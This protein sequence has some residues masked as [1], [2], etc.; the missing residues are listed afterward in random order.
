VAPALDRLNQDTR[1]NFYDCIR[2]LAVTLVLFG[3]YRGLLLPGGSI[4]VSIFFCLSGLLICRILIGLPARSP[5]NIAR[6]IFRRL[7][8]VWP[9]MA[10]QVFLVLGLMAWRQH[11][12]VGQYLAEMPGLLTFT[13]ASFVEWQWLGF[14]PAVLWTLRAEFWFYVLFAAAFYVAGRERIAALAV[15]GIAISW[16]CKYSLGH[17]S[18]MYTMVYLDQLMYGALAALAIDAAPGWLRYFRSRALLW[19]SL[20]AIF[21][22]AAIPFDQYG[23]IWYLQTSD[24]A[25]WTAVLLLHHAANPLRGDY[26]PLATLGRV[27]FSIYLLHAVVL[28]YISPHIVSPAFDGVVIFGIIIGAALITYRAIELPFIALSKRLAPFEPRQSKSP[29]SPLPIP[30][31]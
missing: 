10:F 12:N 26:E 14:G 29:A 7:M 2:A 31:E 4:G 15:I 21:L 5:S 28:D 6:F 23:P 22:L 9:M 19:V 20:L 11:E 27:S 18:G 13:T 30:A 1:D 17:A 3:H 8:R 24:A 25:L 16:I